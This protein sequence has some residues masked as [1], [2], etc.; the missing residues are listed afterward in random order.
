MH[1]NVEVFYEEES[2]MDQAAK[3]KKIDR[4]IELLKS[5]QLAAK[6]RR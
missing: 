6:N 4:N 5:R 2:K 1:D 3:R